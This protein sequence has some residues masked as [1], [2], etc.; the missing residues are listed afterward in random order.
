MNLLSRPLQNLAHR[1]SFDTILKLLEGAR[2]KVIAHTASLSGLDRE[3]SQFDGFSTEG[4]AF[5]TEG[6]LAALRLH[7]WLAAAALRWIGS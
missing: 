4:D 5:A 3:W 7:G 6:D 2:D 1:E